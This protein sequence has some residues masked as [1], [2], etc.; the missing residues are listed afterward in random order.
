MFHHIPA[1]FRAGPGH[2]RVARCVWSST[3]A[4]WMLLQ[5]SSTSAVLAPVPAGSPPPGWGCTT[6]HLTRTRSVQAYFPI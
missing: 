5:E 6:V 1:Q 2:I 4:F 3:P